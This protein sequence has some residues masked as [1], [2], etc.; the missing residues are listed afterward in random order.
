MLGKVQDLYNTGALIKVCDS[1]DVA[2]RAIPVAFRSR[3]VAC[4]TKEWVYSV[5]HG[6]LIVGCWQKTRHGHFD[7]SEGKMGLERGP[8]KSRKNEKSDGN[9]NE[10]D[11]LA[12]ERFA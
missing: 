8:K 4:R 12:A 10:A 1:G 6:I 3:F 11:L 7:A 5:Q 9:I 2:W